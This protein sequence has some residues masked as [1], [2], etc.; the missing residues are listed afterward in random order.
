MSSCQ[1]VMHEQEGL[2]YL[3]DV[4]NS[5]ILRSI[6]WSRIA[7][8]DSSV[9]STKVVRGPIL[10]DVC[11]AAMPVTI[12]SIPMRSGLTLYIVVEIVLV[13]QSWQGG[14]LHGQDVP[15]NGQY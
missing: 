15:A 7:A 14:I 5:H 8:N 10:R 1:V 11:S 12:L 6:F 13:G 9:L 3:H 4:D 2:F